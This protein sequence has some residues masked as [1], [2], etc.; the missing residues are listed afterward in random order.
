MGKDTVAIRVFSR[1]AAKAIR[2]G[3][4]WPDVKFQGLTCPSASPLA[5]LSFATFD[6]CR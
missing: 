3:E 2:M 4:H 5:S 1:I 6:L